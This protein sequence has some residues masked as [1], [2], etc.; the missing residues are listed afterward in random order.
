MS[1][2]KSPATFFKRGFLL[3]NAWIRS[4]YNLLHS[5]WLSYLGL[6][7]FLSP[8][9]YLVARILK[10]LGQIVFFVLVGIY[11]GQSGDADY[12]IIGNA[13]Q[14]IALSGIYGVSTAISGE[15]VSGTLSLIFAA[16]VSQ[17]GLLLGR[18][19]FHMV[20]GMISVGAGFLFGIIFLGLDFSDV[21]LGWLIVSLICVA[22]S[23]AAMGLLVGSVSLVTIN[24]MFFND[25][26]YTIMLIF[27]GVN[28]PVSNLPMILQRFSHML[29]MTRGLEAVRQIFQ[30]ASLYDVRTLLYE[31]VLVGVAYYLIGVL[32]FKFLEM[33][34][35]LGSKS[36]DAF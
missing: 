27:C 13:V 29:P 16:P 35:R 28:I 9:Y 34:S 17:I 12:Y 21:H 5:S 19:L 30:G 33:R 10:P 6:F 15:R 25:V 18:T 24:P 3:R 32:F 36:F 8:I 4:I 11:L 22:A 23:T 20:D 7:T 31:E 14:V 26:I 1:S 2:S